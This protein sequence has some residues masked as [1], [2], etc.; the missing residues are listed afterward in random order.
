MVKVKWLRADPYSL[1]PY[2]FRGKN[3]CQNL[4]PTVDE[5]LGVWDSFSGWRLF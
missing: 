2:V 4:A 1:G 5:G 3:F